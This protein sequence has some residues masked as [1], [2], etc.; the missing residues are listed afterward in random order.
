MAEGAFNLV[1]MSPAVNET[2]QDSL[3]TSRDNSRLQFRSGAFHFP[4][5][6]L[7]RITHQLAHS[8]RGNRYAQNFDRF[9]HGV[10]VQR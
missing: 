4:V 7:C 10:H 9:I 2:F 1:E 6:R 8:A 3:A 5:N